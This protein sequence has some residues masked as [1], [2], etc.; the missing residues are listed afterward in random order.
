MLAQCICKTAE[1]LLVNIISIVRKWE[2]D[3]LSPLKHNAFA[4]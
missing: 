3:N 4:V 2:M 1:Y